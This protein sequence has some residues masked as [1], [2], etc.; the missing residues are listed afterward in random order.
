MGKKSNIV[1]GLDVGT[2]KVCMM[3]AAAHEDG[4]LKLIGTGYA[5]SQGLKKGIVVNLEEAGASIR[6]A[7]AEAEAAPP[8]LNSTTSSFMVCRKSQKSLGLK[9]P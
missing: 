5:N 6:K 8:A 1:C 9:V 3:I 7:A 2:T 4:S